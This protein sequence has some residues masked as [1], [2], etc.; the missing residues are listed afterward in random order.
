MYR[1]RC[2]ICESPG[3]ESLSFGELKLASKATS[4]V[5]FEKVEGELLVKADGHDI[6]RYHHKTYFE[7]K[8][9][10][11]KASTEPFQS[12]EEFIE[13]ER[14]M[15][16]SRQRSRRGLFGRMCYD[17]KNYVKDMLE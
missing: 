2:C 12:M 1:S 4:S 9:E 11:E 13:S 5:A 14:K 10:H 16:R 6:C 7:R 15:H 8:A 17:A 3:I